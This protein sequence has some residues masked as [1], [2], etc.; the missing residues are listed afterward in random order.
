MYEMYERNKR[1]GVT[2]SVKVKDREERR[3]R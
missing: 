2:E 3:R 1:T